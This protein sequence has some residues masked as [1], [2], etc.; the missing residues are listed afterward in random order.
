M[1]KKNLKLVLK[2]FIGIILIITF[3]SCESKS[4]VK[5]EIDV[6]KN[7]RIELQNQVYQ[8][9]KEK[10][11]YIQDVSELE[12]KLKELKIYDSGQKPKY[13]LTLHLKQSH[14]SLSISKHIKDAVNAID[15][16]L[17]V[18]KEFYDKVK[19]G[20]DIVD[21]FRMGSML[22]RGSFGSWKMSVK[23]KKVCIDTNNGKR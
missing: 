10:G 12:S 19:V 3:V 9:Q 20:D 5:S 2:C 14:I 8:L 16:E 23:D 7:Q 17:P 21:E 4:D 18:D 11:T 22:L 6:L 15:F 1:T 13:V